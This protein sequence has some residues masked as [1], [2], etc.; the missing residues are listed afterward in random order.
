[1][2][3]PLD[4]TVGAAVGKTPSFKLKGS[5]EAELVV[6]RNVVVDQLDDV[7]KLAMNVRCGDLRAHD[8]PTLLHVNELIPA[9]CITPRGTRMHKCYLVYVDAP[10]ALHPSREMA[11]QHQR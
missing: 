4:L 7:E 5:K 11:H 9:S 6:S 3:Q 2:E 1:M 10:R 8:W